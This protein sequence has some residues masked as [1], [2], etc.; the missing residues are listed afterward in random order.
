M[1]FSVSCS[2]SLST[3]TL[4]SYILLTSYDSSESNIVGLTNST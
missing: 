1:I 2:I 4:D 3:R